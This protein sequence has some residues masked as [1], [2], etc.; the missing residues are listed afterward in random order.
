VLTKRGLEARGQ[1]V[2]PESELLLRATARCDAELIVRTLEPSAFTVAV[3][4]AALVGTSPAP[5]ELHAV[6]PRAVLVDGINRIAIKHVPPA[7]PAV[8]NMELR[9]SCR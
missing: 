4:G 9:Q 2:V 8:T 3:N 6:V 7:V 5:R 1:V